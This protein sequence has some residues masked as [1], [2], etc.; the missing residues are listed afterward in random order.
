[1][2]ELQAQSATGMAETYINNELE[3]DTHEVKLHMST[4]IALCVDSLCL[5][6]WHHMS[7]I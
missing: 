4:K 2:A 6:F 1:M 3:N 7:C 5:A